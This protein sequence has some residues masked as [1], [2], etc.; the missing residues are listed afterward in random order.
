MG[1]DVFCNSN[2]AHE[3]RRAGSEGLT[4][5]WFATLGHRIRSLCPDYPMIYASPGD[6]SFVRQ[7]AELDKDSDLLADS[8]RLVYLYSSQGKK[9]LSHLPSLSAR[10]EPCPTHPRP[11]VIQD[12][13]RAEM[14]DD[15]SCKVVM[16]R[17]LSNYSLV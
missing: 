6:I 7:F 10:W 4:S 5:C 3:G 14:F 16:F 1:L 15:A 9:L 8:C 2:W 17:R 12:I 11:F 13:K